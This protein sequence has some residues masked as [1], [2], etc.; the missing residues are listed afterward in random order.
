MAD[1]VIDNTL[2]DLLL[3]TRSIKK[4]QLDEAQKTSK[5]L[6]VSLERSLIML[7]FISFETLQPIG[8]VANLVN[9]GQL[10]K[11]QAIEVIKLVKSQG[12]SLDYAIESVMNNPDFATKVESNTGFEL[13]QTD[14]S[15]ILLQSNLVNLE[16]L[17]AVY[18][19]SMANNLH[20]SRA[21]ILDRYLTKQTVNILFGL[22]HLKSEL[23]LSDDFVLKCLKTAHSRQIYPEQILFEQGVK[24]LSS[25]TSLKLPELISL[26]RLISDTEIIECYELE[27]T[28]NKSFPQVVIQSNILNT[29]TVEAALTLLDMVASPTIRAYHAACALKAVKNKGISVYQALAEL[30]PLPQFDKETYSLFELLEICKVLSKEKL[31]GVNASPSDSGI[32]LSRKLISQQLI[33]EIDLNSSLR[34]YSLHKEGIINHDEAINLLTTAFTKKIS[35]DEAIL[36]LGFQLPPRMQW[37]WS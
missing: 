4:E 29:D 35:I 25:G 37:S 26:A 1:K 10:N 24:F 31:T 2:T 20:L 23:G 8:E 14:F 28:E 15:N 22:L 32:A 21:L 12:G 27:I 34:T 3:A 33:S 19:K 36:R 18:Q 13:P 16:Q 9:A 17:K 30:N 11:T 7:N 6:A 5:K